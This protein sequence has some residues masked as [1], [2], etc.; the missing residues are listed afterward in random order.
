MNG[1]SSTAVTGPDRWTDAA[2][3]RDRGTG[4][5]P[6][7]RRR[8]HESANRARPANRI[9]SVG[10]SSDGLVDGGDHRAA[11]G[12]H[13][14]EHQGDQPSAVRG[15]RGR[16]TPR[17][18]G[19]AVDAVRQTLTRPCPVAADRHRFRGAGHRAGGRG[20]QPSVAAEPAGPDHQ[21][22]QAS[23]AQSVAQASDRRLV[24]VVADSPHHLIDDGK[25]QHPFHDDEQIVVR[26]EPVVRGRPDSH[27]SAP[28][29]SARTCATV[30]KYRATDASAIGLSGR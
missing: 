8:V 4:G 20:E 7:Q 2:G 11:V 17:R 1:A 30:S 18:S 22:R 5:R 19:D 29:R 9:G 27:R 23:R 15:R 16:Q 12:D 25:V 21:S 10:I 28:S 24:D 26:G 6:S 14:G 13:V 3:R